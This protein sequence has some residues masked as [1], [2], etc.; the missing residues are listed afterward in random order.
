MECLLLVVRLLKEGRLE[1]AV[2]VLG[3][4]DERLNEEVEGENERV[5]GCSEG[6]IG[7]VKMGNEQ[8]GVVGREREDGTGSVRLI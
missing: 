2:R 7:E 8:D 1:E 4:G 5:G 6:G 3:W